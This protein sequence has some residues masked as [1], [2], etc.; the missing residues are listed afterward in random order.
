VLGAVFSGGLLVIAYI[1]L[2][3]VV[4]PE[5]GG[6]QRVAAAPRAGGAS[7]AETGSEAAG[8][9]SAIGP[10]TMGLPGE[11]LPE[12]EPTERYALEERD[13]AR[14]N[15]RLWAGALLIGLGAIFLAHNLGLFWW[16]QWRIFWPLVLIG[17]GVLLLFYRARR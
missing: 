3:V 16:F 13:T 6:V 12:V 8:E 9:A 10:I 5:T 7:A 4:P 11:D 17:L 14:G 2:W 1:V 15:R